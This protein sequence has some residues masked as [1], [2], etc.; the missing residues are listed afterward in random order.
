[1][2]AVRRDIW[3][4][5]G[6]YN[7]NLFLYTNEYDLS[8]RCWNIGY[9]VIYDPSINAYHRVSSIH[10]TSN[11]LII[12][13]LRNNTIF[14]KSYFYKQYHFKLLFIDRFTWFIKSL[15]CNS[16]RSFLRGLLEAR[17]INKYIIN[18]P[19]SYDIQKFYFNN[20]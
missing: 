12:Y 6:G 19:V 20:S 7:S 18:E 14:I 5:L 1:M 15:I 9:K 11:R 3:N 2:P 16:I 17:K 8:I 4:K 13:S 10:R